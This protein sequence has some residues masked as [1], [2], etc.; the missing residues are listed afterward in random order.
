MPVWK[1]IMTPV[2][3]TFIGY[4]TNWLAVKMLFRPKEEK[5][6]G[7]FKV[8]FTPG[9][10]PKG[11]SR[12]AKAAGKIV[13]EQL[14]TKEALEERL[15][16]DHV[17]DKVR[18]AITDMIEDLKKDEEKTI[19][20][21]ASSTVNEDDLNTAVYQLQQAIVSR[22][23]SRIKNADLG[24]VLSDALMGY[25]QPMISGSFLG[26]MFG[27]SM[28]ATLKPSVAQA[29]DNAIDQYSESV[30]RS[31]VMEETDAL[32]ST[33]GSK[34]INGIES[35]GYDIAGMAVDMY[36][37]AVKEKAGAVIEALDIGSIAEKT[38]ENMNNDQLEELVL[39]TMKTELNAIVN[40]GAVI[41]FILGL[42]NT[43]LYLI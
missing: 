29:I 39:T 35:S 14:L 2:I 6:I 43:L 8:P 20:Q 13:N 36:V 18:E 40:L 24:N 19:R 4:I 33:P 25:V 9:V 28:L 30:V 41:G 26:A 11:K 15:L 3:S 27:E 42:I 7:K 5:Y 17:V 12:L 22:A 37:K 23:D 21:I 1:L 38:V 10:I 16:S 32:L 31:I 34:V